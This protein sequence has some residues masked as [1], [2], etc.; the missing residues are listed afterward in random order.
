MRI[1]IT[2]TNGYIAKNF[3]AYTEN[4]RL[5]SLRDDEWRN[6]SFA[7]YDAILHAA[8]LVH[9]KE[10]RRNQYDYYAI[11]RDLTFE[12]AKKAKADKVGQFV[13]LSTMNVYNL[14]DITDNTIT[15]D[16]PTNPTT[17]YGRSKL[18]AESLIT[19][20]SDDAFR[21]AILRPPIVYGYN[22]PGN[23]Q[24]LYNLI[25]KAPIFPDYKNSRSMVY[26]QNL[27]FF[28][29]S[30]IKEKK[31][32][33]FFPR[34]PTPVATGEMAEAIAKAQGKKLY[35]TRAFNLP[36]DILMPYMSVI[37]KMFGDLVYDSSLPD[38]GDNDLANPVDFKTALMANNYLE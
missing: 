9:K 21:V 32:G 14:T 13:F 7:G 37:Y 28:I 31:E 17:N 25:K 12:L 29:H 11:N 22:C 19:T 4:T 3:A 20:L 16:T 5:I 8:G 15:A 23:F 38:G 2:G 10:N 24:R 36:I 35:L 6:T 1:L 27:C 18:A 26:I 34:D 33:I 30:I